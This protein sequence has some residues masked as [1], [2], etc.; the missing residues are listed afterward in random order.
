MKN[1]TLIISHAHCSDGLS[2]AWVFYKIYPDATFVFAKYGDAPPDVN[3][4]EVYILDFS[5]PRETLLKTNAQARGLL[6][7]DHHKSAKE[8]LED[9]L[10]CQFDMNRSGT[11]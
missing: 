3:G 8:D 9:L 10:F 7:L 11:K 4:K 5:Y 6:V 1:D 2:A